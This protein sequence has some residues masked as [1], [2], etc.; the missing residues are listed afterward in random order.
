MSKRKTRRDADRAAGSEAWAAADAAA[1]L[2]VK[3]RKDAALLSTVRGEF[4]KTL[5]ELG[6]ALR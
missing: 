4:F 5:S 3:G 1:R 6:L 2:V